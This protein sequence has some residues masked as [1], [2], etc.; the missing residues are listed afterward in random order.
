MFEPRTLLVALIV[1]AVLGAIATA[2]FGTIRRR[3]DEAETGIR[4]LAAMRWRE[5]SHF[6]LDAMRHRGYDILTADDEAER[7]QQTE[8]LLGRNG[9]RAM[10]STGVGEIAAGSALA[11]LLPCI[12]PTTVYN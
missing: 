10:L 5:F 4:A 9:E 7:G 1:A 3:Q 2:Y 11:I 8:F 6:V 12:S